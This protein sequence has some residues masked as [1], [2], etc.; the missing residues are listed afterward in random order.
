MIQVSHLSRNYG[1][2]RAVQDLSFTV[3]PG[4]ILG[5]IGANG[6]GK[7]TTL[8]CTAG[9]IPPTGGSI[10]ICGVAMDRDPVG[11]KRQLA[12]IP[13]TPTPFDQLTVIEHLQFVAR[14]FEVDDY[15]AR[16]EALL[17]EFSLE[18]KRNDLPASLSRGM[19]QKL[20]ICQA[21]L[22]DPKVILCDEPLSGLDPLGIRLVR[23]S[24]ERRAAS[25]AALVVSSHQL[26]L[27][28]AICQRILVVHQGRE[29]LHGTLA[30]IRA[31]FPALGEHATLEDVFVAAIDAGVVNDSPGASE[32]SGRPRGAP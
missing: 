23:G 6:A 17:A 10:S 30:E 27:V 8:Y 31:Q 14:V 18:D 25:G 29:I 22:H 9:I 20:A 13:D 21:F 3:A 16:A 26:E 28:S 11:A 32:P 12:F 4:E 5:L 7:T 24:L 1:E 15:K 19:R 2:L